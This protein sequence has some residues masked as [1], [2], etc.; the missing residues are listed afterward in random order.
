MTYAVVL[1]TDGEPGKAGRLDLD[2]KSFSFSDGRRVRYADLTAIYLER[3]PGKPPSLV[4]QPRSG[5][6]LRFVSLEG[7]GALHELAEHIYEG[8]ER[9]AA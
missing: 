8:R 9:V 5:D 6:L 2:P 3:A 1:S 4:V 7:V